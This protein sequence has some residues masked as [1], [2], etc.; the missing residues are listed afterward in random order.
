[1]SWGI[2]IGISEILEKASNG[3]GIGEDEALKL[4]HVP[5]LSGEFYA[6]METANR[7]SRQQFGDKGLMVS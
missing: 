5:V 4:M 1:V 3:G 6:L 7:L 2:N